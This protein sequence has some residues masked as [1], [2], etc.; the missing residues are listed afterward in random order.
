MNGEKTLKIQQRKP[1]DNIDDVDSIIWLTLDGYL[2]RYPFFKSITFKRLE[3]VYSN[4]KS[5]E[6][7]DKCLYQVHS[8]KP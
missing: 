1:C 8:L 7:I 3:L 4:N 2:N 5:L 6:L